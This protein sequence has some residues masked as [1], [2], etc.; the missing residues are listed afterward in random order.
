MQNAKCEMQKGL[1]CREPRGPFAFCI[2][3]FELL[4]E[5]GH[6][7]G[8]SIAVCT[9]VLAIASMA[10]RAQNTNVV[11]QPPTVTGPIATTSALRS[12]DHGYPYNATPVDLAKQG[13]VE[14][15]Y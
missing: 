10:G 2:L 15:E 5:G 11:I 1:L 4:T 7:R 9:T 13:Y 6:M 8:V 14:E 12:P 3:H